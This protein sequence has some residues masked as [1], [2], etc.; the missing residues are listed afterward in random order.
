MKARLS[1]A[2]R[3]NGWFV[4]AAVEGVEMPVSGPHANPGNA[5]TRMG[6]LDGAIGLRTAAGTYVCM[7]DVPEVPLNPQD[8]R[9][10]LDERK[11]FEVVKVDVAAPENRPR[12]VAEDVGHCP[13]CCQHARCA[14]YRS[15]AQRRSRRDG[16]AGRPPVEVIRRPK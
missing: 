13:G 14:G 12:K 8:R 4:I 11:R 16:H 2:H 3:H 6:A 10:R 5:S 1:L 15:E 7:V 9:W